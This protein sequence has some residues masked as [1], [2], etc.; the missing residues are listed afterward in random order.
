[1]VSW[2]KERTNETTSVYAM[3]IVNLATT[4]RALVA[5][6]PTIRE[7]VAKNTTVAPVDVSD[8]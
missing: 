2:L 4:I 8:A 6:D 3:N 5:K 1:M 7:L